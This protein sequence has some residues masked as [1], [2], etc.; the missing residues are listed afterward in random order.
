MVIKLLYFFCFVLKGIS[1][2][3]L[4]DGL[5]DGAYLLI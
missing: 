2:F 3:L 5:W 1:M 4:M